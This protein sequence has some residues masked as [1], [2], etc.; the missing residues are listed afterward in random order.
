MINAEQANRMRQNALSVRHHMTK[1]SNAIYSA[2]F[3][4]HKGIV[5][6]IKDLDRKD[7]DSLIDMLKH[8]G[9]H[10]YID[11]DGNLSISWAK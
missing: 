2:A 7:V 4:G 11:I 6:S 3:E 10:I 9:Y 1:I 8:N 5:H